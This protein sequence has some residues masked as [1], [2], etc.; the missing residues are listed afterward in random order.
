M[1]GFK[2]RLIPTLM[3]AGAA[4]FGMQATNFVEDV[5]QFTSP[6]LA[7]D[8]GSVEQT[9]AQEE[10]G[11]N[12]VIEPPANDGFVD[13]AF[14]SRSEVELLRDLSKRRG[15]LEDR[16]KQIA[17]RERLLEATEKRIDTKINELKQLENQISGLIGQHEEEQNE[18]FDNLV[19]VYEK[20]KAKDA[21]RIFQR[22]DLDIQVSVAQRMKDNKFAPILAEMDSDS[23]RALS[24]KLA[25]KAELPSLNSDG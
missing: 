7:Q 4:L 1:A 15:E 18:Q 24:T 21:A 10:A 19:R 17:L 3:L 8:N 23:A 6:A 9:S 16:E 5:V 2:F 20:M 13:P 14:M 25:Q 12:I 11:Q 22:L